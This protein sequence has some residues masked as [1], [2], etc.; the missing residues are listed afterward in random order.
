MLIA[1]SLQSLSGKTVV[2]FNDEKGRNTITVFSKR[3]KDPE[4]A[5]ESL[6]YEESLNLVSKLAKK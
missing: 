2:Y 4:I 5:I 3:E 1:R 6:N